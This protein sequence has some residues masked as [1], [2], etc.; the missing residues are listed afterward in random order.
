MTL[1]CCAFNSR[2]TTSIALDA[3]RQSMGCTPWWKHIENACKELPDQFR[4]AF[5]ITLY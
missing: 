2:V 5:A 4:T 1:A 3:E